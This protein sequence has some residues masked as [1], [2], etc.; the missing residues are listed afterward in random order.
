[1]LVF[2]DIDGVM[3]S[4]MSWESP[5][6]LSDGFYKFNDRAVRV[7]QNLISED[8][9]VMLTTSH[10]SRYSVEEWKNIF[11]LRWIEVNNLGKLDD[12]VSNRSRKEEI[13]SWV[14]VNGVPNN[15]I[16]LDDDKV[17]KKKFNPKNG[18][19]DALEVDAFLDQVRADYS[20]F[21]DLSQQADII[22]KKIDQLTSKNVDLEALNLQLSRRVK[23][24]ER[25]LA[26][27]G[28]SIEN[29]R[30]IDRYERQLWALGV[31][32]SKIK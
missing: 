29:L 3:V 23:E 12:N 26:K 20:Y 24:L 18:G 30:K 25:L 28:T 5:Q 4:A 32:P 31:D 6:L 16:I 11:S 13:L 1:M 2:L 19:Y 17:L 7:L 22:R 9:T 15:F 27:G 10:K 14:N 21:L 8:T